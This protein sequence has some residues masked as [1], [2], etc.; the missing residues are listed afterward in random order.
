[1]AEEETQQRLQDYS[2]RLSANSTNIALAD[3]RLSVAE[4]Q[5]GEYHV[6]LHEAEDKLLTIKVV[7]EIH[8]T[9]I[10]AFGKLLIGNGTRETIPMDV[11]R[12]ERAIQDILKVNWKQMEADMNALKKWLG[13]AGGAIV[14]MIVERLLGVLFP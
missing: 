7:Q 5:L 10:K 3:Q 13:V 4:R 6:R 8:D 12:L 1:M 9:Q 14:V 11:D 2:V